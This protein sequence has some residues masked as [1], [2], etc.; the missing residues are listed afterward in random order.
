MT[1]TS[2]TIKFVAEGNE[3]YKQGVTD[4]ILGN[5]V[6]P[7]TGDYWWTPPPVNPWTWENQGNNAQTAFAFMANYRY[8]GVEKTA[9]SKVVIDPRPMAEGDHEVVAY[10]CTCAIQG[11]ESNPILRFISVTL[12]GEPSPAVYVN[13]WGTHKPQP[14]CKFYDCP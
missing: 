14:D 12:D 8:D 1:A 10:L 4:L 5:M 6:G 2:I 7:V 9:F 11:S 3:Q 13:E